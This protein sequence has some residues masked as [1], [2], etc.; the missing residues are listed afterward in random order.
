MVLTVRLIGA[1]CLKLLMGTV[2]GIVGQDV[3]LSLTLNETVLLINLNN[4]DSRRA[5]NT[6]V[7]QMFHKE[8][9]M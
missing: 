4:L 7:L 2:A 3:T 8:R 1:A 6:D 5:D 9:C